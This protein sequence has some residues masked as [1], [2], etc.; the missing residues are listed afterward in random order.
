VRLLLLVLHLQRLLVLQQ[1]VVP[2]RQRL[3]VLHLPNVLVLKWIN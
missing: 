2:L 1:L 3:L